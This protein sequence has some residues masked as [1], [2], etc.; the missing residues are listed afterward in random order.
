MLYCLYYLVD[1]TINDQ[2]TRKRSMTRKK[3]NEYV[4]NKKF[5]KEIVDFQRKRFEDPECEIPIALYYM[6]E[7][8]ATNIATQANFSSYTYKDEMIGNAVLD[9]LK[10]LTKFDTTK[11]NPFAYFTSVVRNCFLITMRKEERERNKKDSM[12]MR[13]DKNQDNE[14]RRQLFNHDIKDDYCG[15]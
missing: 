15:F 3:R 9:C 4:N 14:I 10:A 8:I 5:Y 2:D 11:K 1:R 13:Y 6:C 7:A 12:G